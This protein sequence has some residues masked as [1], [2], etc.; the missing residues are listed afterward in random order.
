MRKTK[1]YRYR[2]QRVAAPDYTT[3]NVLR[4]GNQEQLTGQ[5]NGQKASDLEE[6]V[7]KALSKVEA[8]FEFRARITSDALGQ[9]RLTSEFANIRGEIEIDML[10]ERSG[11]TIPIFVDGQISHH[12]APWQA[13]QDKIKTDATNEFGK[14]FGWREAVRIPFWEILDQD[15]ADRRIRNLFA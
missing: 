10:A 5:I 2:V 15:A 8:G 3:E 6:R 11:E 1:P 4:V 12:V 7:A 9:R 13:E 14:Q